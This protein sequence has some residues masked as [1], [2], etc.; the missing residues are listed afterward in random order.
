MPTASYSVPS[1]A[2]PPV[3]PRPRSIAPRSISWAGE[4]H[5]PQNPTRRILRR[6]VLSVVEN[7]ELDT[8]S[9]DSQAEVRSLFTEE[10]VAHLS[11]VND[12]SK[13]LQPR[14]RLNC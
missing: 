11:K 1:G 9:G 8:S 3:P 10:R 13:S 5:P 12:K 14:G 7:S 4:L 2:P 6:K